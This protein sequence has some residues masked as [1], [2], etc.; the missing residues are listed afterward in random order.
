MFGA[1]DFCRCD[2]I[3]PVS[4]AETPRPDKDIARGAVSA[5]AKQETISPDAGKPIAPLPDAYPENG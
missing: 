2:F 1:L 4:A 3:Q 5:G